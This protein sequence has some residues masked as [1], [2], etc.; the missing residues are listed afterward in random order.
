MPILRPTSPRLISFSFPRRR[1]RL[2]GG[3][4]SFPGCCF[5]AVPGLRL[6]QL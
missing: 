5:P 1:L 2:T 6:L 4:Q 3:S